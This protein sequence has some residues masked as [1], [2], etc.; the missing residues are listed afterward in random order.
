MFF[1]MKDLSKPF[2]RVNCD[3]G[4]AVTERVFRPSWLKKEGE[5]AY[6][7]GGKMQEGKI[8]QYFDSESAQPC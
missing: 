2:F 4:G 7:P 8:N 1:I 6:G 5:A 3:W